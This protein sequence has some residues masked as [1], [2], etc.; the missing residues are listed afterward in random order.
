MPEQKH[1]DVRYSGQVYRITL[2]HAHML[3][4]RGHLRSHP[5]CD[6]KPPEYYVETD[7]YIEVREAK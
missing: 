6:G 4:R 5:R 3:A 7:R 1:I 2:D